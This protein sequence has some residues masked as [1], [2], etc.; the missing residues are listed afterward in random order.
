MKRCPQCNQSYADET[1]SFCLSDGS[2]LVYPFDSSSE[3]T[4]IRQSP[5][6]QAPTPASQSFKWVFPLVGILCGLVVVFGFLAFFKEPLPEKTAVSQKN[7]ET[8]E[9]NKKEEPQPTRQ[10]VTTPVAPP[11]APPPPAN[12]TTYPVVTVNSP[13]DGYLALKSEP[14]VA[15]CGATLLKIPHGTRLGLGT[16]KDYFEVA[17]RR[18]GRWCYVSYGGFTGWIFDAFVT[19]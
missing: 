5:L 16:C 8:S 17:D 19:R 10:I 7:S 13:R 2:Q 6:Y 12:Q 18:R 15:P 11:L 4:V 1:L 3:V 9:T 14:C